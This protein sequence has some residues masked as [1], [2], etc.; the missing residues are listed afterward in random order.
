[1]ADASK[2]IFLAMTSEFLVIDALPAFERE[3]MN[4]Y[5]VGQVSAAGRRLR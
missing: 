5:K 4:D 2:G 3:K 1:V